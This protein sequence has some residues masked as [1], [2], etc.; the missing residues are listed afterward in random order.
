[1]D[2]FDAIILM[3][4]KR[5]WHLRRETEVWAR[6]TRLCADYEEKD[7][8]LAKKRSA[9]TAIQGQTMP[10]GSAPSHTKVTQG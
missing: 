7:V 1:M 3:L 8:F 2:P 9:N 5:T 10:P 6:F 4:L